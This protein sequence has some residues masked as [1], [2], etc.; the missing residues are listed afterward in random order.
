MKIRGAAAYFDEVEYT[1][2]FREFNKR[3]DAIATAASWSVIDGIA[4][5]DDSKRLR[6]PCQKNWELHPKQL[7][8]FVE[9]SNKVGSESA[10]VSSKFQ[11]NSS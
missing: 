10:S 3:A 6:P 5:V 1:H 4:A 11:M 7:S 2:V 8:L 9:L